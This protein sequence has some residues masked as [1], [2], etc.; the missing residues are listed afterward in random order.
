M[1]QAVEKAGSLRFLLK[2]AEATIEG[3][4]DERKMT[5]DV[6]EAIAIVRGDEA[7]EDDAD[8]AKAA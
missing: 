5:A 1:D 2:Q 8:E 4:R 3:L 6:R 7:G